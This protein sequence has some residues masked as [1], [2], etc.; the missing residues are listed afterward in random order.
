MLLRRSHTYDNEIKVNI[1]YKSRSILRLLMP[2][3]QWYQGI[4]SCRVD[5]IKKN[6]KYGIGHALSF[7]RQWYWGVVC[8]FGLWPSDQFELPPKQDD[9]TLPQFCRFS[10]QV[11]YSYYYQ[12]HTYHKHLGG[13]HIIRLITNIEPFQYMCTWQLLGDVLVVDWRKG[14]NIEIIFLGF[15][16]VHWFILLMKKYGHFGKNGSIYFNMLL[17]SIVIHVTQ[18]FMRMPFIHNGNS[19]TDKTKSWY[20]TAPRGLYYY[21]IHSL[22]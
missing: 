2:W 17:F 16:E 4:S 13:R 21:Q 12:W 7:K 10:P 14:C 15:R 19:H 3:Y 6:N 22:S 20:Q 1:D 8:S 18:S 9:S 5:L 11:C